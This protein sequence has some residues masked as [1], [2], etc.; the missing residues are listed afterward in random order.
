MK[1]IS[2]I[3]ATILLLIITIALAGTAYMF[4]SGM[5]TSKISKTIS[6]MSGSCNATNYITLVIS[7]DGTDT[8]KETDLKIFNGSVNIPSGPGGFKPIFIAPKDSN[9]TTFQG[10]TGSNPVSVIS[11][12]NSIDFPVWC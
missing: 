6:I 7:N 9:I 3:I 1:G 2:T 4:I 5:L 8:I 11:P 10:S 12:S